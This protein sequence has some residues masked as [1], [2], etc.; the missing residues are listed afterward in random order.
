M[1]TRGL[2]RLAVCA[3][4]LLVLGC[5]APPPE[6]S[7]PTPEPTP[8]STIELDLTGYPTERPI[9]PV[10]DVRPAGVVEPPAGRGLDRYLAQ[11]LRWSPCPTDEFSDCAWALVPLDYAKPDR[12]AVTLRLRRIVG[13][14]EPR[15]G[16]L[17]LN[18]G[19]PGVSGVEFL[20]NFDRDGLRQYDLVG[21]DPRGVGEST[22][23]S[24]DLNLLTRYIDADQSPD[25]QTE[26]DALSEL[27]EAFGTS[28]LRRSGALLAHLST[29]DT[30]RDLDLLRSLLGDEKLNYVGLSYGTGLGSLYA[31]MYPER[32]GR[33]VLDGAVD[34][35]TTDDPSI[36]ATERQLHRFVEFCLDLGDCRLGTDGD[37]IVKRIQSMLRSADSD[38][39]SGGNPKLTQWLIAMAIRHGLNA[40]SSSWLRLTVALQTA[41]EDDIGTGLSE[42]SNEALDRQ[43]DGGLGRPVASGVAISCA[44]RDLGGVAERVAAA[45]KAAVASPVLGSEFGLDVTCSQWPVAATSHR[46]IGAVVPPMLVIGTDGDPITPSEEAEKLAKK[47]TG[48][49]FLAHHGS[50]HVAHWQSS[51]VRDHVRR[52]LTSGAVPPADTHCDS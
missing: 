34:F 39:P 3:A 45:Q 25:S 20:G 5:T 22:P 32:V 33:M 2:P 7:K 15:L 44:D 6:S 4:M 51:C 12:A 27:A 1:T 29:E 49:V 37:D 9:A 8:E 47:L 23:V 14:D 21:W 17:F 35:D 41:L 24:C 30:V 16:T 18:F 46:A 10:P 26:L 43:P 31:S 13:R 48:A 52:Y 38:P 50:A 28:C 36:A 40:G 19:G 11:R 42:L